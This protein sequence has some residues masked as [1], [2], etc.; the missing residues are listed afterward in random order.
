VAHPFKRWISA[1]SRRQWLRLILLGATFSGMLCCLPRW[2]NTRQYPL[3]PLLPP[4]MLLSTG[5]NVLLLVLVLAALVLATKF[6]RSAGLFFL[7]ATLYLFGCDQ[8]REQPWFFIYWV[9]LLLNLL[10]EPTALAACRLAFTL[11]YFWAGMQKMN[12]SFFR[13][14]PPWFVQPAAHWGLPAAIITGLRTGV[15]L[16]PFLE[17][18]IAVGVWFGRTR[19]PAILI[20]ITLHVAALLFLGPLGHKVNQVIWPWNI[21]MIGLLAVLFITKE[22]RLP[23]QTFHHIRRSMLAIVVVGLYGLLPVLNFFGLWDSYLSFALYSYNTAIAEVYVSPAGL[24]RLP[25]TLQTF[26]HPTQNLNPTMQLPYMLD[27]TTWAESEMGVPPLPEPRA[28]LV[29]FQYLAAYVTNDDDCWMLLKT[30][31]GKVLLYRGS[32]A[33]P[34]VLRP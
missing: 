16:T 13:D 32:H 29:V 12:S 14:V 3:V 19:W 30:R 27:Q 17:I 11:I 8:N 25:P 26:L 15:M 2:L 7:L 9:L 5:G 33:D 1:N 34:V 31:T 10:P 23:V 21:A 22:N 4:G 20:A 6:F 28:D 24:T 18:F